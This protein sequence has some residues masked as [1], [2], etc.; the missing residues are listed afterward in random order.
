[1]TDT[2]ALWRAE[3]TNFATLIDLLEDQ[4]DLFHGGADADYDLMLAI[5]YYMIHYPD[6]YHHP[7]EDLAF[8]LIKK[9]D[10]SATALVETLTSEHVQ[11]ARDGAALVA[12]LDDIMNGSFVSRER[13]ETMGRNYV[14]QFRRHM[15]R[16]DADAIPLAAK[17]LHDKDWHAINAKIRHAEDPIFGKGAEQRYAGLRAHI[18]RGKSLEGSP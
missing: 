1:M 9:R 15:Q 10:P 16:E 12:E 6:L 2:I 13:V 5:A 3:H 17:L 18:A 8:A 7:R 11:I 14:A 4:L